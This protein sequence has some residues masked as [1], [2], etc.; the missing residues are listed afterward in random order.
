MEQLPRESMAGTKPSM[1]APSA[2]PSSPKVYI[3]LYRSNTYDFHQAPLD[4]AIDVYS[5]Q[6]SAKAN[7]RRY[8]KDALEKQLDKYD[9]PFRTKEEREEVKG[10]EWFYD[11]YDGEGS[12]DEGWY[13]VMGD[14]D[15][16]RRLE[17]RVVERELKSGDD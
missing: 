11:E 3:L 13:Y 16:R 2:P 12:D 8:V 14:E 1:L 9:P 4:G 5:S 6:S 7:A 17:V 10:R 15:G